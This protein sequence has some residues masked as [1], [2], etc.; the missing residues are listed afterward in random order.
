MASFQFI[1]W[2][3]IVYSEAYEQ[4]K[5]LFENAL[6]KKSKDIQVENKLIFCQHPHVI[7][8]GKHGKYGNLL[9]PETFLK[10]NGISLF[11]IDR[12]G[13]IT[14]HGQGQLVVYPIFDIEDFQL[15]L[16]SYIY[17]LEE[18]IILLLKEY[19]ISGQRMNDATGVWLDV[20]N[21]STVRKICAIGVKSSRYVTMHGLALNVNTDL[22]YFRFI[23]HCGFVYKGVT[24]MQKELGEEV[25]FMQIKVKLLAIFQE[26]FQKR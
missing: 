18:A 12:G 19:G 16:K 3:M 9:Y 7:T 17:L 10:E 23:N 11:Q 22:D 2:D 6:D 13:D 24:S 14:Y 1:D 21:P 5:K 4:Q 20:E 8:I 25:S 15:G 26:I